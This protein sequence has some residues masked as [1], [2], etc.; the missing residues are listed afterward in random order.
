MTPSRAVV[1]LA[2]G[3]AFLPIISCTTGSEM[4]VWPLPPGIMDGVLGDDGEP[5]P[6]DIE[7]LPGGLS[8]IPCMAGRLNDTV[9]PWLG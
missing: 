9:M 7:G 4:L 6:T 1:L 3:F 5:I 8:E 2:C